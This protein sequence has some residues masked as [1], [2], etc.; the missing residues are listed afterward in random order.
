M[1]LRERQ[2]NLSAQPERPTP[3]KEGPGAKAKID[4]EDIA[5]S[6]ASYLRGRQQQRRESWFTLKPTW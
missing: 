5:G 1:S 3:S 2:Q 4:S 6:S